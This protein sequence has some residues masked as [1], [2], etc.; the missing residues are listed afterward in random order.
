[1]LPLLSELCDVLN[2][3]ANT[4]LAIR[5]TLEFPDMTDQ[6]GRPK[7]L[8]INRILHGNGVKYRPSDDEEAE[9]VEPCGI[10]Y[11][12]RGKGVPTVIFDWTEYD[13]RLGTV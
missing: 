1:M 13:F 11:V 3:D 2:V 8:R 12:D 4:A 10:L 7:L 5:S 6:I 9:A